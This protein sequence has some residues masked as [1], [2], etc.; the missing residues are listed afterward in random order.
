MATEV[1]HLEKQQ[2][3]LNSDFESP[4]VVALRDN[5]VA[6]EKLTWN[7]ILSIFVRDAC[8]WKISAA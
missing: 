8:I 3:P 4:H 6:P 7:T 5:P 2:H 1:Q